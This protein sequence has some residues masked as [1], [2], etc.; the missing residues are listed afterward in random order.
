M[1]YDYAT[2][3]ERYG[4]GRLPGGTVGGI[5]ASMGTPAVP[6]REQEQRAR[7]ARDQLVKLGWAPHQAAGIV[8]NLFNESG[9]NPGAIG[10]SGQAYGVAQWHAD[11]RAAIE[12]GVGKPVVGMSVE[13]QVN[14]VDWE[15]RHTE[16]AAGDRIRASRTAAEA[17]DATSRYYERPRNVDVEASNRAASA[18]AFDRRWARNPAPPPAAE[19]AS[20]RDGESPAP[21]ASGG[22][23]EEIS[24]F[25]QSQIKQT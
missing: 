6:K 21:A 2:P 25:L 8:A 20:R 18:D 3:S 11:R 23:R 15:L 4:F 1:S 13:E 19:G 9:M 12:K 22:S 24:Q 17:G 7:A 16:K 10:D 14:A 5:P